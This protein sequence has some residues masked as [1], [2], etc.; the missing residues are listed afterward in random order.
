LLMG[1][2]GGFPYPPALWLRRAKPAPANALTMGT[3]GGFP[4]PPALWL[5]RAKPAS[6][7]AFTKSK[8]VTS[9]PC[10]PCASGID[11]STSTTSVSPRWRA[12]SW[13]W[14]S[15]ARGRLHILG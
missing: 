4:Y 12:C 9:S 13:S 15:C 8:L 1:T 11:R 3:L 2:L 7:N 6:A 5:R 14:S 10:A